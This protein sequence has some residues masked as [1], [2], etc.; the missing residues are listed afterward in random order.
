[1]RV[2]IGHGGNFWLRPCASKSAS[3]GVFWSRQMHFLGL[4]NAFFGLDFAEKPCLTSRQTLFL[5]K[6]NVFSGFA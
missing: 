1:M 5:G 3:K 6:A 4:P 2:E